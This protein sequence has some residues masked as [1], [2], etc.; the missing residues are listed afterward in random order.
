MHKVWRLGVVLALIAV[1]CRAEVN[2]VVEV[3]EDGSGLYAAEV[4]LD[5]ELQEIFA[6]FGAES[7]DFLSNFDLD[8]PEESETTERVEGDMTY[9][10]T[11]FTFDS[12]EELD[13]VIAS[14]SASA[15]ASSQ[16][17]KFNLT[18]DE[19]GAEL[20]AEIVVPDA[21]EGLSEAEG[22][23]LDPTK[24]T[25]EFFSV[26]VIV[27]MPGT[28][29]ESNAD[30]TL[31]DGRLLVGPP[32]HRWQCGGLRRLNDGRG[33]LPVVD[34]RCRVARSLCPAGVVVLQPPVRP[35]ARQGDPGRQRGR[36]PGQQRPQ[37]G[38][39]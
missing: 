17:E 26:N 34:H 5:K 28:V 10:V 6:N 35:A 21:T 37:L 11:T 33:Q 18:V 19:N 20:D 15:D 23:G 13:A 8:L 1:A 3:E 22:L 25:D 24:L 12:P 32:A 38:G 7:G 9:A 14:A 27:G 30:R 39:C 31:S 16:F 2:V 36:R 29:E 4:G